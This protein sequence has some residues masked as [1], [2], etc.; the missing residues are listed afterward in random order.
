MHA[1]H[2]AEECGTKMRIVELVDG[3]LA[4]VQKRVGNT[5]DIA[6]IYGNVRVNAG[7]SYDNNA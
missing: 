5:G 3:N 1:L 6:A 4:G 2:L 7:L